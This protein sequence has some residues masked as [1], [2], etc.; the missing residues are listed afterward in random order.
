MPG[1]YMPLVLQ[2]AKIQM[3]LDPPFRTERDKFS[4]D[5]SKW[6][7]MWTAMWTVNGHDMWCSKWTSD[8]TPCPPSEQSQSYGVVFL[9]LIK[10]NMIK[11][12]DYI[13]LS[14]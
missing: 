14:H 1:M 7:A 4:C 12:F 6:T 13:R 2:L 8:C 9:D 10:P 5:L 11:Y 3:A